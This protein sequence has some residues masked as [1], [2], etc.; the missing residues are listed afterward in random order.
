MSFPRYPAYKPSG[1]E[2]LGE[3]PERWEV[4]PL[5]RNARLL[6][7]KTDA[8]L[9]PVVLENIEGWTGKL[10]ETETEF[11]GEGV[12]FQAGDVLFGKLRPYL[13]KVYLASQSGEAVGDFHVIRPSAS[14]RSRFLQYQLL[15]NEVIDL[16]NGSTYGAKMP[17]AS[18]N[19]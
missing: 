9:N 16:V 7:E 10:I 2:W 5:K 11:Q 13:A 6:T 19:F 4:L 17:R 14:L 3:V 8:R 15:T 12:A 18:W 1:V